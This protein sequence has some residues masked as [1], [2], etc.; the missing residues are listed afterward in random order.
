MSKERLTELRDRLFEL[1]RRI[2]PLEWDASRHQINEF[3]KVELTRLK[4]EQTGLVKELGDLEI[5]PVT[6]A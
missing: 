1:E 5:Q 3:K 6:P 4:E 2:R